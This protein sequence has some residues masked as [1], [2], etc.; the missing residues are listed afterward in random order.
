MLV[1]STVNTPELTTLYAVVEKVDNDGLP[2]SPRMIWDHS[3]EEFVNISAL[4]PTSDAYIPLA[5]DTLVPGYYTVSV[6]DINQEAE[7]ILVRVIYWSSPSDPYT[8]GEA[9]NLPGDVTPPV[10]LSFEVNE[11]RD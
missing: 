5:E 1:I 7:N 11:D 4:S 6:T 10:T 2:L 8:L 9:I 3:I